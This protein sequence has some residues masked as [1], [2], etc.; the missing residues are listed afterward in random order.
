MIKKISVVDANDER[1]ELNAKRIIFSTNDGG[2]LEID[3][4]GINKA[5]LTMNAPRNQQTEAARL[6][7]IYP[8]ACNLVS[9]KITPIN[10]KPV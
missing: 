7:Q 8:G 10:G 4:G 1:V 9:L 6:I 5:D 2:E 3:F